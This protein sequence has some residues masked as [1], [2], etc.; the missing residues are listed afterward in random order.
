MSDFVVALHLG[1]LSL[2]TLCHNIT[3]LRLL[4]I[5]FRYNKL[6]QNERTVGLEK[7]F[8]CSDSMKVGNNYNGALKLE[9]AWRVPSSHELEQHQMKV[10]G[11]EEIIGSL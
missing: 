6:S 11:A 4:W 7:K 5:S 10:F 8:V 2:L 3:V 9:R 1:T